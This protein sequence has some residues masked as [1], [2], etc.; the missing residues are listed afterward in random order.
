MIKIAAAVETTE[1]MM[2]AA[3]LVEA[4]HLMLVDVDKYEILE[5]ISSSDPTARDVSFAEQ[6]V[7]WDCE[8]IICGDID[9]TAFE[10][11]ADQG[12][13]RYLGAGH[14]A[15]EAIE[16]MN[17]YHLPLIKEYNG[18][19]GCQGEEIHKNYFGTYNK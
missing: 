11:L 1:A 15:L 13:T 18:G 6:A 3:K 9:Q 19:E 16:L 7:K 5:I 14:T 17:A 4:T 2:I 8:A 10:I 12:V